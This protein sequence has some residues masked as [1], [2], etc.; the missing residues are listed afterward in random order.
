MDK[1]VESRMGRLY[2]LKTEL[3][4]SIENLNKLNVQYDVLVGIIKDSGKED[5][6][7]D[8]FVSSIGEY[9]NNLSNQ[10]TIINERLSYL[11]EIITAYEKQDKKATEIDRIVSLTLASLGLGISN[12]EQS[13]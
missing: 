3:A 13:E 8:D 1:K 10:L 2:E 9:K 12:D 7:P 5:Q 6:L 4:R 11:N